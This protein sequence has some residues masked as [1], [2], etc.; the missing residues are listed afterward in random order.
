MTKVKDLAQMAALVVYDRDTG[1]FT[2]LDG[3]P[4]GKP[5]CKGYVS[6][7]IGGHEALAHRLAWFCVYGEQPEKLDHVNRIKN[8]NRIDNLRPATASQNQCNRGVQSNSSS[9]VAGVARNTRNTAWQAYIKL[10]GKRRHLG[11]FQDFA[12]AVRARR[13]A[14]S[15]L[16][17]AFAPNATA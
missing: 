7:K 16:F 1:S 3:R 10:H 4:I 12:E 2:R 6:V 13:V 17:G 11:L 5:H 15:E 8:D 9:G 14:E